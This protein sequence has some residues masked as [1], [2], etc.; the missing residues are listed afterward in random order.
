MDSIR[1]I[2]DAPARGSWNMAVD[3]AL[4]Q[5]AEQTGWTTFRLYRWEE[6]T[7]SLGYFQQG[8][9][10]ATHATSRHCPL[11]RRSTGGGAILHDRELTYSLAVPIAAITNRKTH[12]WYRIAHT[13]LVAT[14][15]QYGV[16]T[17]LCP[18]TDRGRE[19]AF[20]CFQR[21]SQGD[22]LL[23]GAKV[24]GSAQR[25]R[26]RAL[27]QHGSLLLD[28]SK[29]APELPGIRQL[30]AK[31]LE[32]PIFLASWLRCLAC[33]LGIQ[34]HHTSL[35]TIELR[36]AEAIERERFGNTRWALRR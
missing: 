21:R 30:A 4:L 1:L 15:A 36:L 31:R 25:R 18:K 9:A 33:R 6:P 13:T 29:A 2:V 14:L 19:G 23:R 20:L 16:K 3:E 27:L 26:H 12:H 5:T 11:V 28:R 17:H 24:A 8:S 10:R 35:D 7:L 32:M 22:V 34:W